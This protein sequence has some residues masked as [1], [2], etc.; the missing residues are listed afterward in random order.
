[1]LEDNIAS[2]EEIGKL[3]SFFE[4]DIHKSLD[5]AMT[6][7]ML[8]KLYSTKEL[9]H[10]KLTESV[11]DSYD[12]AYMKEIVD[13]ILT[14]LPQLEEA[15]KDYD[16]CIDDFMMPKEEF[17][18]ITESFIL[19]AKKHYSAICKNFNMENCE[20][21]ALIDIYHTMMRCF[22]ETVYD[23]VEE[24][25]NAEKEYKFISKKLTDLKKVNDSKLI[26]KD[27]KDIQKSIK[28]EDNKEY[29]EESLQNL[30]NVY[31][32]N[33]YCKRVDKAI[34]SKIDV[35]E[36]D[37]I[38]LKNEIEIELKNLLVKQCDDLNKINELLKEI[39]IRERTFNGVL[40]DNRNLKEEAEHQNKDLIQRCKKLNELGLEQL[41]VLKKEISS[42]NYNIAITNPFIQQ[43]DSRVL[44]LQRKE[45]AEIYNQSKNDK[46]KLSN[47][48]KEIQSLKY[49]S[50][51][52]DEY[53]SKIDADIKAIEHKELSEIC[54]DINNLQEDKIQNIKEK[55][56]QYNGIS[57]EKQK[58][59]ETID[60]KI[61]AIWKKEDGGKF[62]QILLQTDIHNKQEIEKNIK[63]I[64]ENG[65]TE[66]K[67]AYIE[68]LQGMTEENLNIVSAYQ[69][70]T[71]KILLGIIIII[72]LIFL[73][74]SCVSNSGVI[75]AF[76]TISF[77]GMVIFA[78]YFLT[79]RSK[80]KKIWNTITIN[81]SVI[82]PKLKPKK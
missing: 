6:R 44:E 40:Y 78:I 3:A 58:Y 64:E 34:E 5:V 32:H 69:K 27:I 18:K 41:G 54:K 80:Y 67:K 65:R 51:T 16:I 50:K 66:S 42:L 49:D 57:D 38:Q 9:K 23:T 63:Y 28:Y 79:K 26:N 36:K 77:W 82:N 22:N 29:F 4:V 72:F 25:N 14:M 7:E 15:Y 75:E 39:D 43:I 76:G 12:D 81:E 53:T 52:T 70:G 24:K 19:D 61:E 46:N 8:Q 47:C 60:K 48:K 10:T 45:I 31:I 62:D 74:A 55:V 59:L 37:V 33:K 71:I 1:M 30:A 21:L 11:R 2:I 56:K 20:V 68:A 73:I 17:E 35:S 13:G